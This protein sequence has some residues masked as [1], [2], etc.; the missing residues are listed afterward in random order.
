MRRR[1]LL[2]DDSVTIQKVI[3]LTFMD[4][5]YEVKAVSNGDEALAAL[6]EM[7]PD[8]V[9]A[10][11]HMP[12]ANG[13]DVCRRTKETHPGV[14]VLLLVGTFEPF[15]EGQ[16]RAAGADS[17]LKKPFDSQELLQRVQDLLGGGSAEPAAEAVAAP[18]FESPDALPPLDLG[19]AAFEPAAP[20]TDWSAFRLEP[21]AAP[22]EEPFPTSFPETQPFTPHDESPF[23]VE[24]E[25]AV[26]AFEVEDSVELPGGE[27]A[28]A[29]PE[30]EPEP[31]DQPAALGSIELDEPPSPAPRPVA[32]FK[33][34]L[35]A[36]E[37]A[38]APS[39]APEPAPPVAAPLPPA[40]AAPSVP[41]TAAPELPVEPVLP[42]PQAPAPPPPPAES[43][44]AANGDRRLSD[45][46]VERIAR[47]VVE[48]TGDRAVR[49]IA[50][51]VI[52]DLAEVV[53]RD[54]LRELEGQVENPAE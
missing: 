17:F 28:L 47:R 5:D 4:E 21:A 44:G 3:E 11:V 45:D 16:S 14:P 46:D 43:G 30:P 24:E 18:V 40:A 12:G 22:V 31:L 48:L 39:P 10:D 49:D 27:F 1:I 41:V 50:W 35:P 32:G 23:V 34:W 54:R 13:Y 25:Q 6:S 19:P 20:E 29:R 52:P 2:A 9:I 26:T 53:I 38:P 37:P 36:E 8:F 42:V 33:P 51:E 7:Q 15:D